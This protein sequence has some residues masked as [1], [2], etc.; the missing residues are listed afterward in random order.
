MSSTLNLARKLRPKTFN[1]VIGQ[2]IAISMLRNS[3]YK[4]HFFPVYL[5]AG[6]KGCGKT[7]TAR[8]LAA[9]INCQALSAFQ[10]K[11]SLQLPCLTCASCRHMATGNH[12]DFIEIDAASHTGVDDVRMILESCNF[13]PLLGTK[14]IY[15]IDEAHMLSKAAFN[16]FLKILEEPPTHAVFMMATTE[17]IKIPDTVR[18]RAFQLHFS[19]IQNKP[20]ADYLATVCQAENISFEPDALALI[21]HETEGSARD[22]LN[23][24]E[25]IRFAHD[26]ITANTVRSVLG[27]ISPQRMAELFALMVEKNA[28][29]LLQELSTTV[30]TALN[31]ARI[32]QLLLQLIR[33]LIW[34][35]YGVTPPQEALILPAEITARIMQATTTKEL[36]AILN[37][38]WHQEELF[39]QTPYKNA[40]LEKIFLDICQVVTA[41]IQKPQSTPPASRPAAT[42]HKIPAP[43]VPAAQSAFASTELRPTSQPQA[44][45]TMPSGTNGNW[46]SVC[47]EIATLGD[48][49]LLSI[50][51][52]GSIASTD[53]TSGVLTLAVP[54]VSS[55]FIEK[56]ND[57]HIGWKPIIQKHF[58][59]TSIKLVTAPKEPAPIPRQQSAAVANLT[60]PPPAPAAP[61]KPITIPTARPAQTTTPQP[62]QKQGYQAKPKQI[63]LP[64]SVIRGTALVLNDDNKSQWPYTSLLFGVFSGKL[65]IIT[66]EPT[67]YID[68]ES[69][70]HE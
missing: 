57:S 67:Q 41:P 24:L 53:T 25:Q 39:L 18:S 30:T 42:P 58:E 5:F 68:S 60:P 3:L 26:G 59:C 55:F 65:E 19:A 4:N 8:I 32:W 43:P 45:A 66:P 50:F 16:A 62:F 20:L 46:R 36:Q 48:P 69:Y 1:D 34:H 27:I 63:T 21:I 61:P 7:S 52:Q 51:N 56:I 47:A 2:E 40:F 44:I 22:A 70:P 31:P 49:I 6:Q 28:Q 9:A 11:P 10:K 14:K 54:H 38:L 15:L 12:P 17:M 23:L 37:H 35:S 33:S 64:T 13:M 29:A